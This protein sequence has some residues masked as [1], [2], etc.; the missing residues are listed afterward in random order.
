MDTGIFRQSRNCKGARASAGLRAPRMSGL[1]LENLDMAFQAT[2]PPVHFDDCDRT[3][4]DRACMNHSGAIALKLGAISVAWLGVFAPA[5]F[6][7]PLCKRSEH[8][9]LCRLHLLP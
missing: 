5:R 1:N 3:R 4:R 9:S 2:P 7:G 6:T 8:R